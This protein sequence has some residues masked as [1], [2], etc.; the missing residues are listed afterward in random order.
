[1]DILKV[2]FTII[3]TY[4][5]AGFASGKEIYLY[6]YRYGKYCLIGI[7]F[8]CIIIGYVSYK[9]IKI[10][11]NY[12]IK[13]YNEFLDNIVSNKKVKNMLL[14]VSDCFLVLSFCVM[15]SGFC[16]LAKQEFNINKIISYIFIISVCVYCFFRDT[17]AIIKINNILIPIIIVSI[18]YLL[19]IIYSDK[20]YS[21]C[22]VSSKENILIDNFFISCILYSNYNL[23]SIIPIN[24]VMTKMYKNKKM[25]MYISVFSCGVIFILAISIFYILMFGTE[26]SL[27]Q[28][29]PIIAI[30]NKFGIKYTCSYLF[31][32]GFSIVTTAIS[33]GY[34]YLKKIE[35]KRSY[36]N[37]LLMIL[38]LSL[39]LIHI[40]FSNLISFLYPLFGTVGTI[41]SY[42][43]LK[44]IE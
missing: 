8:M 21:I 18:I 2:V 12:N 26:N 33:A 32:I 20:T 28:E 37:H 5:G 9:S 14:L 22:Y 25:A 41:Q 10:I 43:I 24:I 36:N 13:N 23:L 3:A 16:S 30:V 7:C 4:V 1:M 19:L 31:I 38:V 39:A 34:S 15:I 29:M 44:K 17:R 40:G 27:S 6:F 11:K 35:N 42:Y